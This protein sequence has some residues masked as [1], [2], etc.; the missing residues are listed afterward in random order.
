MVAVPPTTSAVPAPD[1]VPTTEC[2]ERGYC[3]PSLTIDIVVPIDGANEVVDTATCPLVLELTATGTTTVVIG[4]ITISLEVGWVLCYYGSCA[5]V[6]TMSTMS[7]LELP[8][9]P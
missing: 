6:Y 2:A 3:P 5:R 8:N 1:V 7:L 4:H 9:R